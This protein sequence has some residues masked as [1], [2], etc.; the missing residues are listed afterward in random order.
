MP[1]LHLRERQRQRQRDRERERQRERE[2][3]RETER[4]RDRER[5]RDQLRQAV[6]RSQ[7]GQRDS[8]GPWQRQHAAATVHIFPHGGQL[9]PRVRRAPEQVALPQQHGTPLICKMTVRRLP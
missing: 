6:E 3:E 8:P 4:E 9:R 2:R 5:E 7:T 1:R